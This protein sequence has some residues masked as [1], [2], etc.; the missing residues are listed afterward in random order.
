VIE[1]SIEC[2]NEL[3]YG[4]FMALDAFLFTGINMFFRD[5]QLAQ[6]GFFFIS[7]D[8]WLHG[9]RYDLQ[10]DHASDPAYGG[11]YPPATGLDTGV[12]FFRV[13]QRCLL[14]VQTL[15]DHYAHD[16][17]VVAFHLQNVRA[18]GREL[19]QN[20]AP[21]AILIDGRLEIC[22][23]KADCHAFAR[24]GPAP[25]RRSAS[26]CSTMWS[27]MIAGSFTSA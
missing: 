8:A 2:P 18:A 13:I 5:Y 3:T 1:K 12:L 11:V 19:W 20:R 23:T 25:Y 24:T 26:A 7:F 10:R 15:M 9:E 14:D 22:L 17:R 27:E 6:E 4:D 21:L 16:Q